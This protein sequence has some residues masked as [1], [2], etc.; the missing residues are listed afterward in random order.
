MISRLCIFSIAFCVILTFCADLSAQT[1]DVTGK[2]PSA[3][4]ILGNPAYRAISFG[5]FR[6]ATRESAPSVDELK[7]DMRLLSAAGIKVL[8]T[9][10]TQQFPHAE[11]V[12]MAIN[13]LKEE[14]PEFEMYVILGAWIDC[15]GAWTDQPDHSK[16]SAANNQAEIDAAVRLANT[17][18]DIVKVIAVGNEAMVH[19]ASSYYVVPDVILKWVTFL[20]DL[21]H[22]SGLPADLWVTSSDNFASWGGGDASYHLDAL[23]ELIRA[24]DFVSLHTY[25][26]HDTHYNPDFWGLD[27]TEQAVDP[28]QQAYFV[29]T[30]AIDY[31]I[32]QYYSTKQYVHSIAPD[33]PVHIGETGWASMDGNLYGANGSK[34]AD[35]YKAGLYHDAMRAWTDSMGITCFFFEAFD[36]QWKDPT[37]TA[38]SE[39][40]FGLFTIDG[41][42]KYAL[43]DLV[44]Q[45]VFEGMGRNG[46]PVEKT[47]KGEIDLLLKDLLLPEAK[48]GR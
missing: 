14:N 17:Y 30:D 13:A 42:A 10:N 35:E 36:E 19:W 40:H 27:D 8:R 4:D 45:G 26:F 38:G 15:A 6:G 46:R 18:P 29:M 24:V 16:G 12:L 37:S 22:N 3:E 7:E 20:Q 39:N 21:K 2:S 25:P 44:D 9:Y 28:I 43:W 47:Y 23:A 31:A 33:K 5:G 48:G 1:S 32:K 41:K 34:A 11:R